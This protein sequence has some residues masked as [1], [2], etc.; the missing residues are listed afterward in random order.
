M[1]TVSGAGQD[2]RTFGWIPSVEISHIYYNYLIHQ[3]ILIY[4]LP[5]KQDWQML[6]YYLI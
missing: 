2:L 3:I 1:S 4:L 5:S 6:I